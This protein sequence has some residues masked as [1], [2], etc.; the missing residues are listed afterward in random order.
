[1]SAPRPSRPLGTIE[2]VMLVLL[3]ALIMY[4]GGRLIAD[5]LLADWAAALLFPAG[6]L[7]FWFGFC[8][9]RRVGAMP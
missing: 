5:A 6:A 4:F 8:W 2:R 1:M 3:G 7:V 9:V